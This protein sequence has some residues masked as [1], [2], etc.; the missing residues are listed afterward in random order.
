MLVAFLSAGSAAEEITADGTVWKG[1]SGELK[2]LYLIGIYDGEVI[3]LQATSQMTSTIGIELV[4]SLRKY[5]M[6]PYIRAIDKFYEDSKHIDVQVRD[7]YKHCT[8]EF[9]RA[10]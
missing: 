10:K 9:S 1:F 4:R 8:L 7:A 3:A 5:G 6:M 2:A